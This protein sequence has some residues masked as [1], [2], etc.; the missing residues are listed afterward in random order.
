[1]EYYA[2]ISDF[3]KP[4]TN[5]QAIT[6]INP[7]AMVNDIYGNLYIA[8]SA[9]YS[10]HRLT[11]YG[12]LEPVCGPF[13]LAPSSQADNIGTTTNL[14]INTGAIPFISEI[15]KNIP[16]K[17]AYSVKINSPTS[18][19][20]DSNMDLICTS[21]DGC[22]II[23]ISK[24]DDFEPTV[25]IL[26]GV[27]ADIYNIS[28]YSSRKYV[29]KYANLQYP[30]CITYLYKSD[31]FYF[32]NKSGTDTSVLRSFKNKINTVKF[33]GNNGILPYGLVN[34]T[35]ITAD[36]FDYIIYDS[37]DLIYYLNN[38]GVYYYNTVSPRKLNTTI[39]SSPKGLCLYNQIYLYY[40]NTGN[41]KIEYIDISL[42]TQTLPVPTFT[43]VVVPL[44]DDYLGTVKHLTVHD[45]GC[46]WVSSFATIKILYLKARVL[47]LKSIEIAG[48]TSGQTQIEYGPI[49]VDSTTNSLYITRVFQAR[50]RRRN[51]DDNGGSD[52]DLIR[53]DS[54]HCNSIIRRRPQR[55]TYR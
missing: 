48:S 10:I 39:L 9:T 31:S 19:T 30:N 38:T 3:I 28:D 37:Y 7:C 52:I 53:I 51:V 42:M 36:K 18:L 47:A 5:P 32:S 1:M 41:K 54:S 14:N 11:P 29:G 40:I 45:N 27:G 55:C 49:C 16:Y 25:E 4:V 26:S 44:V 46:M 22:Q 8:D 12:A 2:F 6:L 24:I 50:R 21:Y 20:F 17:H 43:S 34:K 35:T 33:K 15:V 23:K 13:R